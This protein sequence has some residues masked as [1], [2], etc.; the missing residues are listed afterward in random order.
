MSIKRIAGLD[1]AHFAGPNRLNGTV[2]LG[3]CQGVSW[4]QLSTYTLLWKIFKKNDGICAASEIFCGLGGRGTGLINLI[5][6]LKPY[7]G[8]LTAM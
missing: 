2:F 6:E 5:N 8:C 7:A 4:E 1:R 3:Y